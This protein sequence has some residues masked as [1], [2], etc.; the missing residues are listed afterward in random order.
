[1]G[2]SMAENLLKR[3]HSVTV[4]DLNPAAVKRLVAAGAAEAKR[5][6]DV[7]AN[8]SDVIITMLPSSPHVRQVY[9]GEDGV[10]SGVKPGALL[11]D[12]STISPSVSRELTVAAADH[13]ALMI[14]A[15]VSGG[16]CSLVFCGCV[17]SVV[18]EAFQMPTI[19]VCLICRCGRCCGG[20]TDVHGGRRR[21]VVST[22]QADFTM[23]GQECRAV[24]R[25][26][27]WSSGQALQ[28]SCTPAKP[29]LIIDGQ[30]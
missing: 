15:P 8:G 3:G 23:H 27:Q 10:L 5:P 30:W 25:T 29:V 13:D 16:S 12:A 7:A 2:A 4:A 20:Y 1:M 24:R 26:G 6:A 9:L 11:I 17:H 19:A 28:Q 22:R 14:D 18:Y 21:S